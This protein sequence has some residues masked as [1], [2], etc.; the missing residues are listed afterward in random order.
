MS[1][2]TPPPS[3]LSTLS[4]EVEVLRVVGLDAIV[5]EEQQQYSNMTLYY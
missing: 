5:P 4:L 3:T 2:D 1:T